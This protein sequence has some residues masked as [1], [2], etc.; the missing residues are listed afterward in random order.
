MAREGATPASIDAD[1]FLAGTIQH[2]QEQNVIVRNLGKMFCL[3]F[4]DGPDGTRCRYAT[5][6]APG[7]EVFIKELVLS[8]DGV[9]A[10]GRT[11]Y[12]NEH[13]AEMWVTVRS[14]LNR[15]G[16]LRPT[17]YVVPQ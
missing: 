7:A 9:R 10:S 2:C 3:P 17:W 6:L 12:L 11:D 8:A 15:V 4:Y 5:P 1:R 16:R 13:S 14:R